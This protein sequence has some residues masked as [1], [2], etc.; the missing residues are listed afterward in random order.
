MQ[1][2]DIGEVD[3]DKLEEE[4][5]KDEKIERLKKLANEPVHCSA[6]VEQKYKAKL[7]KKFIYALCS[8]AVSFMILC[9]GLVCSMV[10]TSKASDVVE[11][12]GYDEANARY[13]VEMTTDI[14][15]S[16]LNGEISYS[17][18]NKRLKEVENL[19]K[20]E[21]VKTALGKDEADKLKALNTGATVGTCSILPLTI[22]T[23]IAGG[24][25]LVYAMQN[26]SEKR[27]RDAR[28]ARHARM[29]GGK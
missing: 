22:T 11:K 27:M 23:G 13:K 5:N 19:D 20:Y 2:S 21:H 3:L 25:A 10:C 16:F 17:E 26:G 7:K 12:S 18:Y 6:F 15:E 9:A 14:N 24:L 28:D 1:L 8:S 4:M 29:L